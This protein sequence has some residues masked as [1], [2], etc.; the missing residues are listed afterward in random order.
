M[1]PT[2]DELVDNPRDMFAN[3]TAREDPIY[4][5]LL[6]QNPHAHRAEALH[7]RPRRAEAGEHVR[8]PR[9]VQAAARHDLHLVVAV[10][11]RL[12]DDGARGDDVGAPRSSAR[13]ATP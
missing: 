1:E 12:L 8:G 5:H 10:A 7:A 13:C 11:R 2:T 6:A 4:Q 9:D 3:I